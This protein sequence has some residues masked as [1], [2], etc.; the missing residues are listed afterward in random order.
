M[1]TLPYSSEGSP[2]LAV[3]RHCFK[4]NIP[5]FHYNLLLVV[6]LDKKKHQSDRVWQPAGDS[7][8]RWRDFFKFEVRQT[9]IVICSE[10]PHPTQQVQILKQARQTAITICSGL[11]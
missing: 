10:L 3:F 6:T 1:K 4:L 5:G 2:A 7:I 8:G 11:L 9:A